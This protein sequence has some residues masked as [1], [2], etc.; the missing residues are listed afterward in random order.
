MT[1]D[2]SPSLANSKSNLFDEQNGYLYK[3]ERSTATTNRPYWTRK[4]FWL[5][6]HRVLHQHDSE[7]QAQKK[8]W[9]A[10]KK[11][12]TFLEDGVQGVFQDDTNTGDDSDPDKHRFWH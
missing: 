6:G 12:R 2:V 4:F 11:N 10:T 7:E 3:Q 9:S 8:A 1:S 5:T